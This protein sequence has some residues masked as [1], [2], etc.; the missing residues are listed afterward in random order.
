MAYESPV[1]HLI[2]CTVCLMQDIIKERIF[3][4]N[5]KRG[6]DIARVQIPYRI[7]SFCRALT[8]VSS[9]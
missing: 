9:C 4:F 2:L 6:Q 7:Y 8:I 5:D 3:K 1:I